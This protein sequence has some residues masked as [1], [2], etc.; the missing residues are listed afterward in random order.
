MAI[1]HMDMVSRIIGVKLQTGF[2]LK[3]Y[4][5]ELKDIV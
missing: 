5:L 1:I 3:N 4:C 2:Q